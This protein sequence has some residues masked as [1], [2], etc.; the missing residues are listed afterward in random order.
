MRWP[1]RVLFIGAHCDDVELFA[2]GA[3]HALARSGH[4]VGVMVFSDHRGVLSEAQ[5]KQAQRELEANLSWLE[6]VSGRPLRRHLPASAE[7]WMPACRGEF[8][9]ERGR[10]YASMERV[11]A[12][13]DLVV[14]HALSDTNQDHHQVALEARRVFKGRCT[15]LGGEFPAN[16]LGEFQA[17]VY[18]PLTEGDVAAKVTMIDRYASQRVG[19]RPYLSGHS[20]RGLA[21]TRGAQVHATWAEAFT[22]LGRVHSSLNDRVS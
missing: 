16:D 11:R 17:Q 22:V 10:L 4:D 13:Y 14:T 2:G 19:E 20:V 3:L 12:D 21:A 18:L 1:Q 15:L 5:A 7:A 8:E 6:G 9:R